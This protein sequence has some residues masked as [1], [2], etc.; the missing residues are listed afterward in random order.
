MDSSAKDFWVAPFQSNREDEER[1]AG[2]CIDDGHMRP[3]CLS[4][5][6]HN[7]FLHLC[8]PWL[9]VTDTV[10]HFGNHRSAIV[11]RNAVNML[12]CCTEIIYWQT[13]LVK[14]STLLY[15]TP[16]TSADSL[17]NCGADQHK[18]L[19]RSWK[20]GIRLAPEV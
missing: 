17:I 8:L 1:Q 2:V 9:A 18:E 15:R 12:Y 13:A 11:M 14:T 19:E 5:G 4:V 3:L 10:M 6:E 20:V 7:A 16:Q